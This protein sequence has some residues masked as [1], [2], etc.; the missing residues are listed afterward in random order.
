MK[1]Q[2]GLVV[3]LG[4]GETSATIR[5]VYHWLFERSVSSIHIGILETPAGI[6]PNSD[7]VVGGI[8][9]FMK[10]RLKNFQPQILVIPARKRGTAFSP[11][12]PE[13][14]APLLE[15]NVIMMGPGS[16]TYAVRQL[17]ASVAWH[18]LTARHRLGADLIFAS[19]ATIASSAHALP[20]YEIY[21]VGEHLHW[22]LGLNLLEPFGL[23]LV[24]IPHWNNSDGG[25]EL[26]T[27]RCYMGKARFDQLVGML[28]AEPT[29]VGIDE[30]TALIIDLTAGVAQIMGIGN[31]TVVRHGHE[32]VFATGQVFDMC[33]LGSFQHL[34]DPLTGIPSRVWDWVV[35]AQAEVEQREERVLVPSLKVLSLLEEG[36]T[37]RAHKDWARYA[38]AT[39]CVPNS[40]THST[41]GRG[42]TGQGRQGQ[43]SEAEGVS[44]QF[45]PGLPKIW[46][47]PGV[48][49]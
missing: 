17:Q 30:H 13:I 12:D 18:T 19:A 43:V 29:L 14:L 1:S 44:P 47:R 15:A 22:K 16:P 27:S 37:A 20:V 45:T 33:E 4:S 38:G 2:P 32:K 31:V 25:T 35:T 24:F 26:D 21:K 36:T 39:G 40:W 10:K 6:E 42:Y 8:A 34:P 49:S 7:H 11:D 41:A 5:K 3:L 48:S 23:S 9:D 46:D 28:P